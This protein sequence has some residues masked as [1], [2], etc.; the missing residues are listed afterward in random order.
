MEPY[1]CGEHQR[2]LVVEV[3]TQLFVQRIGDGDE[4]FL[5]IGFLRHISCEDS[6]FIV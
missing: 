4:D 3:L 6:L 2:L 5:E 1:A